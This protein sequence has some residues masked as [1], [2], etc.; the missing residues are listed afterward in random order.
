MIALFKDQLVKQ[1]NTLSILQQSFFTHVFLWM[2]L[3]GIS[4]N[5]LKPILRHY[6]CTNTDSKIVGSRSMTT[7]W[8]IIS[9]VI[10]SYLGLTPFI[11][12]GYFVNHITC[13]ILN[14]T[15][16]YQSIP[17]LS[18]FVAYLWYDLIFNKISTMYKFH[19]I[20][21][22]IP[23]VWFISIEHS[24]GIVFAEIL[25]IAEISTIFLNLKMITSGLIKNIVTL[26]FMI[27]FVVFRPV[28]MPQVLFKMFECMPLSLDNKLQYDAPYIVMTG[29]F[30]CIMILNLYWTVLIIKKAYST[31]FNPK[32]D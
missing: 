2:V 7:Q 15:D 21:C 12:H 22:S 29:V 11:K 23:V 20:I 5:L 19:H 6:G 27:T 1:L 26:L 8:L 9:S 18:L 24:A 25:M 28:Y 4:Y 17:V 30:T 3:L 32:S 10:T 13:D 16:I 31:G 14:N